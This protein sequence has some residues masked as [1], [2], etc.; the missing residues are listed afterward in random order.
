MAGQRERNCYG[1]VLKSGR[2]SQANIQLGYHDPDLHQ[3]NERGA[4]PLAFNHSNI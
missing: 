3:T 1:Y 4:G 2:K